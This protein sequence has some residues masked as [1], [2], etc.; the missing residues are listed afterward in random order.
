MG[1]ILEQA[2]Q[3]LAP[4]D[5]LAGLGAA[6]RSMLAGSL[7]LLDDGRFTQR[8]SERAEQLRKAIGEHY[9]R[10][11]GAEINS[12]DAE[13][14][15]SRQEAYEDSPATDIEL[16]AA[17]YI[18]LREALGLPPRISASARGCTFLADDI[19]A[20]LIHLLDPPRMTKSGKRWLHQRGWLEKEEEAT[21]LA[22]I[23]FPILDEIF[24]DALQ[25]REDAPDADDR[26]QELLKAL[27]QM[28]TLT[29]A[30]QKKLLEGVNTDA[31]NDAALHKMII[32]GGTWGAFGASVSATGF[33]TYVMAAQASA[34][35]PMISGPGLVSFVSV[36]SNPITVL[37][38]TTFAV[39]WLARSAKQRTNTAVAARIVATLA[40]RGLQSGR[41]TIEV[42][43]D[44]FAAI[45]LLGPSHGLDNAAIEGYRTEWNKVSKLFPHDSSLR[46]D[47]TLMAKMQSRLSDDGRTKNGAGSEERV[48]AAAMSALT[49]GDILYSAAAVDPT[50]I[51]AADFSRV[52]DIDGTIA[53]SEL[54]TNVLNGSAA[55]IRGASS[56]LEG[57]VAEQA[58]ASELVAAGHVVSFPAASNQAGWDLLVDG[59]PFQVKFHADAQGI[60]EHFQFHDYPVIA[61]TELAGNLPE[62]YQDHVFFVDGLSNEL[63]DDVTQRS[64]EAGA[65]MA[66]PDVIAAASSISLARGLMAYHS[67]RISGRQAT[68][69]VILDGLVRGSLAG[70]AGV[71]GAAVGGLVFG[72]A[73]A[74]VFGPGAPILAQMQTARVKELLRKQLRSQAQCDWQE[75]VHSGL[76]A[77]QTRISD[78]LRR[79]QKQ[80]AGKL[81]QLPGND[82]G[83][84]MRWR[85]ADDGRFVTECIE[86]ID[87][88][89][90]SAFE[91]PEQRRDELCR[92]SVAALHRVHFQVELC[93]LSERIEQRPGISALMEELAEQ[94]WVKR[95][96]DQLTKSAGDLDRYAEETGIKEQGRVLV[97]RFNRSLEGLVSRATSAR[98]RPDGKPEDSSK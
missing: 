68:E 63:I 18:R 14:V 80:L 34:F 29:E 90:R 2:R 38:G 19:T 69:Q 23:V 87:A 86:R 62:A 40:L 48:N 25:G 97:K 89:D 36:L 82:A 37:G 88:L 28:A 33:S 71:V 52:A 9:G 17:L 78:S 39:W 67:G 30:Q 32:T 21:K 4:P 6:D 22:D 56:Q 26:R 54:A 94:P 41:A 65:A 35:V 24:S 92:I 3:L 10:A 49:V 5:V 43:R 46:P 76:D 44:S 83:R 12:D 60:R 75:Q 57:Y 72:P 53:F 98:P 15:L 11:T 84:Y 96:R 8:L 50:V 77:L 93:K 13:E 95:V 51:A 74:W 70:S 81:V 58:V 61:N 66:E 47:D 20:R 73:G 45:P 55:S 31:V 85:L 42:L 91:F 79:K 64:L 7:A 16:R 59:K 1:R 27:R